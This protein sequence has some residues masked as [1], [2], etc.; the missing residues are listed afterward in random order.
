MSDRFQ[1][2][3]IMRC[4]GCK[5]EWETIIIPRKMI[6]CPNCEGFKS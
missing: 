3:A 1:R 2:K 6:P 5:H 4:K